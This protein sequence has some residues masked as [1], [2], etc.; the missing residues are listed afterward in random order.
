MD[1]T[2]TPRQQ[3]VLGLLKNKSGKVLIISRIAPERGSDGTYLNWA[4]PGGVVEAG[5]TSEEAVVREMRHET[6]YETRVVKL[7]SERDHPN[8][9]VHI[10]YYQCDILNLRTSVVEETDEIDKMKWVDP[11]K[12]MEYFTS[13]VDPKVAQY[14]GI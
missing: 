7:I 2:E 14:L 4:F 3:I 9:P 10:K 8:Y 5:E 12:I 11:M 1:D 13:T 6:G